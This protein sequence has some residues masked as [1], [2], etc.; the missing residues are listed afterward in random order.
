MGYGLAIQL[1]I[2]N[3]KIRKL[4]MG[5]NRTSLTM[6]EI[7]QLGPTKSVFIVTNAGHQQSENGSDQVC[8]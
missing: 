8:G 4:R 6:K 5:T 3:K 2:N 1:I 7:G